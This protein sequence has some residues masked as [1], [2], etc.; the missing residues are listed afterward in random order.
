MG[1][2]ELDLVPDKSDRENKNTLSKLDVG[3]PQGT[4]PRDSP[5]ELPQRVSPKGPP[6]PRDPQRD[7]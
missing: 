7:L 6:K 4:P 3:L 2:L 1:N 5:K